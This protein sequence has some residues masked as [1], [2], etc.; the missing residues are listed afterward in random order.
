[1][2]ALFLTIALLG[3]DGAFGRS[4][5]DLTGDN[6]DN[7]DLG[8][9]E[10]QAKAGVYF[11]SYYGGDDTIDTNDP[12]LTDL[13][14][15]KLGAIDFTRLTRAK[16]SVDTL[17]DSLVTANSVTSP[18]PPPTPKTTVDGG[19]SADLWH[20]TD[21][22][23]VN[24]TIGLGPSRPSLLAPPASPSPGRGRVTLLPTLLH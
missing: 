7:T 2:L 10:L 17:R 22:I 24:S 6:H 21:S 1:M 20:T 3:T 9:S 23:T 11:P 16:L 19:F 18:S 5:I 4:T 14:A 12:A 13:F 8:G 15:N